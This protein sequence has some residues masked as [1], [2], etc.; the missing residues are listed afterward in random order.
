MVRGAQIG[1][2]DCATGEN[3]AHRAADPPQ[4]EPAKAAQC[5]AARRPPRRASRGLALTYREKWPR[6]CR[7][8]LG[9]NPS[10]EPLCVE[11]A[12]ARVI[13][14]RMGPRRRLGDTWC[15]GAHLGIM[16]VM[17]FARWH[18]NWG[19]S[20]VPSI[21]D[22]ASRRSFFTW[23]THL[24]MYHLCELRVRDSILRSSSCRVAHLQR[25]HGATEGAV[26]TASAS[27]TPRL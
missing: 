10:A 25:G 15:M 19:A 26:R 13:Q 23:R 5:T 21:V 24:V 9:Q 11:A 2:S 20:R 12:L 17:K 3:L 8:R 22:L 27:G 4:N 7:H 1:H 14:R 6:V 16:F 18:V